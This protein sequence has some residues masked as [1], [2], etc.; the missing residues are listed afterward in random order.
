[1]T[2]RDLTSACVLTA[3]IAIACTSSALAGQSR[4]AGQVA[5]A[6]TKPWTA[7][8]A[9][10]QPDL[11]GIW[12][13]FDETPFETPGGPTRRRPGE[14][15]NDAGRQERAQRAAVESRVAAG[16]DAPSNPFYAEGPIRS[17]KV[18]VR[19]SLVVDPP[20]GKVPL[21]PGMAEKHNAIIDQFYDSYV[22]QTPIDRCVTRGVPTESFPA[23][24]N[25][26]RFIQAPGYVAIVSE[27]IHN[28]RV[29][30]MDGRPHLP[31]SVRLWNGDS[32]GRWDGNTLVV[33]TTNFNTKGSATNQAGSGYLQGIRQ[34]EALRV[35][36]RFTRISED[37]IDYEVTIN[38][39]NVYTRPWKVALP[40]NRDDSYRM[41][42]YACH[43]GNYYFMHRVLGAGR[44]RDKGPGADV[45]AASASRKA[46][47]AAATTRGK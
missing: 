24:N 46:A 8:T 35:V 20:D 4:P 21:Q 32:R 45:E 3:A 10:G 12:L 41:F 27:Q 13:F 7:Q 33:E 42:E 43:E 47:E 18:P 26:K 17:S 2:H 34:S 28:A 31:S 5:T 6:E 14:S 9:D 40:L 39:P 22:F 30:P 15:A 25:S 37:R 36:E 38:D 11:A 16:R 23:Q 19:P 44:L 29:I 1:M